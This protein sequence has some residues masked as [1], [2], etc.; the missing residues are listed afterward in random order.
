MT[1]PFRAWV[2][3]EDKVIFPVINFFKEYIGWLNEHRKI[4]L[5]LGL[6]WAYNLNALTILTEAFA[7]LFYFSAA[8]GD[9]KI[10]TQIA[11]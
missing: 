3:I 1:K 11:N 4:V 5:L 6:I 7:Y 8:G 9:W 10:Y 2:K